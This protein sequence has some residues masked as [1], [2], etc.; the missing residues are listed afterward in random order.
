MQQHVAVL[1]MWYQSVSPSKHCL[2]IQ[3]TGRHASEMIESAVAPVTSVMKV[4]LV[5]VLLGF[6]MTP[7]ANRSC[8]VLV[9]AVL[10]LLSI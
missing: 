9:V 8:R 3:C 4:Y 5:K 2:P 7:R 10:V 1:R 6:W